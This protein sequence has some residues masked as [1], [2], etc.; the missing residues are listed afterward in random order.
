M[1]KEKDSYWITTV[2]IGL[3]LFLPLFYLLS[4]GPV[5]YIIKINGGNFESLSNF[6]MPIILVA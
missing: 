6:Y 4:I 5:G 1:N 3:M 2:F